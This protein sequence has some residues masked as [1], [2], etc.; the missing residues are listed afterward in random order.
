L[1]KLFN[2]QYVLHRFFLPPPHF[3][4]LLQWR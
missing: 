2:I 4:M 1:T 3:V